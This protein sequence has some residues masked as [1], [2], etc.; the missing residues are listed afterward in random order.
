M[1]DNKLTA[2]FTRAQMPTQNKLMRLIAFQNWI[3]EQHTI[4]GFG[5]VSS[6]NF[7]VAQRD[8]TLMK[9]G[10]G[11]QSSEDLKPLS[12]EIKE[13]EPWLGKMNDW[14][15]KNVNSLPSFRSAVELMVFLWY[16]QFEALHPS[17]MTMMMRQNMMPSI[18]VLWH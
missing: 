12:K 4:L 3:R 10:T 16:I 1:D 14:Q 6:S 2:C 7:T 13:P 18:K 8:A 5:N 9:I 11:K 17:I 15:K